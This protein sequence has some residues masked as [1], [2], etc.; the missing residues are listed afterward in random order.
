MFFPRTYIHNRWAVTTK[1]MFR[2]FNL[3]FFLHFRSSGLCIKYSL[4]LLRLC[5]LRRI[6][7]FCRF[8]MF[9]IRL[10]HLVFG[11]YKQAQSKMELTLKG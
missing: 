4:A 10:R 1:F 7:Y 8:V 11:L 2:L 3:N 9:S 6:Q 5:D